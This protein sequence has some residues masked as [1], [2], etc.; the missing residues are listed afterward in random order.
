M[1]HE[2]GGSP[3]RRPILDKYD[4]IETGGEVKSEPEIEQPRNEEMNFELKRRSVNFADE[5][6]GGFAT[7]TGRRS[8]FSGARRRRCRG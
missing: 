5:S 3:V 4:F 7:A 8:K 1:S 6:R 2:M